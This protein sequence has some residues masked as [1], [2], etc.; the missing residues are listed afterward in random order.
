MIRIEKLLWCDCNTPATA[1]T[2]TTTIT[3]SYQLGL[4]C[5]PPTTCPPLITCSSVTCPTPLPCQG[6]YFVKICTLHVELLCRGV[7]GDMRKK[8]EKYVGGWSYGKAIT[9]VM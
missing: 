3:T 7:V 4:S 5:P 9:M 6:I 8:I 1:T 2:I